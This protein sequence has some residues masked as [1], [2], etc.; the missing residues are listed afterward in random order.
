MNRK[1]VLITSA[2]ATVIVL[3]GV[4][5]TVVVGDSSESIPANADAAQTV[6]TQESDPSEREDETEKES[7]PEAAQAGSAETYAP[8]QDSKLP[9]TDKALS[10][11]QA[12][13]AEPK[14][15]I[16]P[17]VAD[18]FGVELDDVFSANTT[19]K[20]YPQTWTDI[21]EQSA[22][23][24]VKVEDPNKEPEYYSALLERVNDD[25]KLVAT[26]DYEGEIPK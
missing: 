17:E 10:G 18:H 24:V 2:V 4:V 26:L 19:I 25:W 8:V 20:P 1:K 12:L 13:P 22:I 23:V 14:K 15:M 21:D 7:E 5:I 11:L 3:V 6:A 16:D 9:E